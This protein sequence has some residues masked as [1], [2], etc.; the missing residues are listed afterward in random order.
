MQFKIGKKD[1][2]ALQ[3]YPTEDLRV[4]NEFTKELQKEL[5][6]FIV[7]VVLFGSSARKQTTEKSDID[8]LIVGNDVEFQM[9]NE[10]IE[11]YKIILEKMISKHSVRLHVTSMT[12]SSF[13]DYARAGDPVTVNILR[14]GV[15]L[16][17][18]GFFKPT[19]MLLRQGRIRPSEESLWR[20]FSRAPKTLDN[21]RWH[22][23]QATLDL[24]WAVIDS[25][26][27]ALMKKNQVPP[28]PDHVA[29]L[30]HEVYVK[31]NEL[32][33]KY[34]ETM[35]MFYKLSKVIV[36]REIKE[37]KGPEYEKY[38][39]QAADFVNRMKKLIYAH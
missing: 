2:D 15:A 17:D 10:F 38:F 5:Q 36:H 25:A 16:Y 23:M 3:R 4:A 32:E 6:D 19:Q 21:S 27:A 18:V 34:V 33:P 29:D 1:D 14:D 9:T 26:H 37:I 20:Y 13:W 8:V 30:L 24:Y 39:V 12:F 28:S 11:T 22:V 7:A 31:R 35:R